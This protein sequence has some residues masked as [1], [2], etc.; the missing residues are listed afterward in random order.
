MTYKLTFILPFG[1]SQRWAPTLNRWAF[2]LALRLHR[3]LWAVM[4]LV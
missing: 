4:W 3:E 2:R 1:K